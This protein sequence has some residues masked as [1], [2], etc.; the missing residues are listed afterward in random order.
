VAGGDRH[1]KAATAELITDPDARA[2]REAENGVRQFKAA[3]EVIREYVQGETKRFRLTQS[4]VL[5]LHE[6]ALDG[7]HRWPGHMEIRP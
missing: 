2:R 7:I 3:I 5:D 4:L 6:K 1:S